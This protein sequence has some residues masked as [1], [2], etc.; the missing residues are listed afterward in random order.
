VAENSIQNEA[1]LRHVA[2]I[3]DGNGRWAK[4]QGKKTIS[5]HQQGAKTLKKIVEAAVQ[6]KIEY[7][8]VYAFSSENWLRPK[9]E[10]EGLMGIMR[11]M[12]KNE[13]K[14]LYEQNIRLKV[15]GNI[16]LLPGDLQDLIRKVEEK[17][18]TNNALTL[19]IALSYGSRQEIIQAVKKMAEK[20]SSGNIGI[21]EI[22]EDKFDS[23]L[24]T[25]GIPDPDLLIRT[26]GEQRISNFLLWQS[27]YTEFYFT[28]VYWPDFSVE[29]FKKAIEVYYRRKRRFG[30]RV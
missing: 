17:S 21:E 6:E 13:V 25:Q 23:V 2:I 12:L 7:L 5:G 1:T 4:E 11:H 20:V 27:A 14:K 22:T 19:V 28:S 26:S 16:S 9:E 8:T 30:L 10:V 29:E 24:Y 15:I 3:M 18:L